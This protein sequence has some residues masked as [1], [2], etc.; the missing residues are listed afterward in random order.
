VTCPDFMLVR[1]GDGRRSVG[2]SPGSLLGMNRLV[3]ELGGIASLTNDTPLTSESENQGEMMRK[4]SVTSS[5]SRRRFL[6][7]SSRKN[8]KIA[9]LKSL[10]ASW[11]LLWVMC[12]CIKPQS[13][14]IGSRCGQQVGMKWSL[15]RQPG[16]T[17]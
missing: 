4:L 1:K 8:V 17:S 11:H 6:G 10:K 3:A 13:R 14:S 2:T 15:I 12:L 5:Q 16:R 7:T 9:P